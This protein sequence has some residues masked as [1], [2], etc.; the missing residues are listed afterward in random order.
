MIDS[1]AILFYASRPEARRPAHRPQ[2]DARRSAPLGQRPF[3]ARR[4]QRIGEPLHVLPQFRHRRRLPIARLQ[5]R[6]DITQP[7]RR[8]AVAIEHRAVVGDLEPHADRIRHDQPVR[9]Q[10][11]EQRSRTRAEVRCRPRAV[12]DRAHL[13]TLVD[14]R[15]APAH[16]HADAVRM[17]AVARHPPRDGRDAASLEFRLQP[18]GRLGR[19]AV[20]MHVPVRP[21]M[22]QEA[23]ALVARQLAPQRR[24]RRA[25][26]TDHVSPVA[27]SAN[28]VAHRAHVMAHVR[29]R[30][31]AGRQPIVVGRR[32]V[33]LT[34]RER[35]QPVAR[36]HV[37]RR[38]VAPGAQIEHHVH[39]REP[40][41]H[42]QHRRI[43]RDA[44]QR[45]R[46]PWIAN[47]GMAVVEL[48]LRFGDE[49]I[50]AHFVAAAQHDAVGL[51]HRAAVHRDRAARAAVDGRDS[52]RAAHHATK[53]DAR[54]RL[55]DRLGQARLEVVAVDPPR[56]EA[57]A[58]DAR[59]AP[60]RVSIEVVI[61]AGHRAH[62]AGG[63]V[64]QMA[65]RARAV[66]H[67]ARHRARPVDQQHPHRPHRRPSQQ[68]RRQRRPAKPRTDN[69]NRRRAHCFPVRLDGAARPAS[70]TSIRSSP[71]PDRARRRVATS[72]PP[73]HHRIATASPPHRRGGAAEAGGRAAPSRSMPGRFASNERARSFMSAA[74]R[75]AS[76]RRAPRAWAAAAM[77]RDT[78]T[79]PS[80]AP[81]PRTPS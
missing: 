44:A 60:A 81:I 74:A 48:A 21:D 45:A 11:A 28:R 32:R 20:A 1:Y 9:I 57:A 46:L 65:E 55:L 41:A 54:V 10:V 13:E 49:R 23:P 37:N 72:S 75:R 26:R 19:A 4:E 62:P 52:H 66:R 38:R 7:R 16:R 15:A 63:H 40:A 79:P 39:H 2:A 34:V 3:V 18:C 43:G 22:A 64:Q 80:S 27:A 6:S 58:R 69:R 35:H 29:A 61:V 71:P 42:E 17:L 78:P 36:H 5:Q 14:G 67:A 31:H 76:A 30:E 8:R 59:I 73:H 51:D 47:V 77:P 50:A 33:H 68:M 24:R 25:Q 12:D 53:F 70:P 56:H